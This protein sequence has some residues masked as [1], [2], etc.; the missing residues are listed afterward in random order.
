MEYI[1]KFLYLQIETFDFNLIVFE[2]F[3]G[4]SQFVN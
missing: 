1:S 2:V 4:N 3:A